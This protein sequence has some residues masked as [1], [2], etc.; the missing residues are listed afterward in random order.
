MKRHLIAPDAFCVRANALWARQWLLLASGDFASGDFNAMTVGWG[1]FGNM[2]GAPFA[3]IVVRP[4]RHTY[5]FMERYPTFTLSAFP[6]VHRPALSL[7][8]SKSGRDGDKIDEAGLTPEAATQVAAP[9]FAEAELIVE[10]RKVYWDDLEPRQFLVDSTAGHYPEGDY[11]RV[12]FGE[13]IAVTGASTFDA[14][15]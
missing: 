11:H 8:G 3:Q 10:C 15:S 6:A 13:I 14:D 5:T 7:L 2:W 4:S 1:S 12:Y 9:G